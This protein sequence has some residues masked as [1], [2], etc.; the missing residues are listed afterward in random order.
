MESLLLEF[1]WEDSNRKVLQC[2]ETAQKVADAIQVP[3][4]LDQ[5]KMTDAPDKRQ[6]PQD[7]FSSYASLV[8]AVKQG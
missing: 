5:Q 6:S 1:T 7:E 8:E 2:R 4:L 3:L